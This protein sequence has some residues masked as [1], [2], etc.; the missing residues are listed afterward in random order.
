MAVVLSPDGQ[1]VLLLRRELFWL[2]DLP[3]GGVEPGEDW[4]DA[5]I[6][7]TREETGYEIEVERMVGD[8]LCQSVY[9]RG[10]QLTRVFRAHA[11]SGQAKRFGLE[12]SGLHWFPV[13]RLPRGVQSLQRQMIADALTD[14][15]EPFERRIDFPVWQLQPARVAF[16]VMRWRNKLAR[17]VLRRGHG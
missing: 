5:A 6:R 13:T 1:R 16:F 3:G 15:R 10:D 17:W 12:T 4:A 2:W 7:E 8:Y 11:V 14:A 9:G